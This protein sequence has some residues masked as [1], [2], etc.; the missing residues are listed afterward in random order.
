MSKVNWRDQLRVIDIYI[1]NQCQAGCPSCSRFD[2][3]LWPFLLDHTK[4]YEDYP[5]KVAELLGMD[6]MPKEKVIRLL[7]N[8]VPRGLDYC[9]KFCGEF[10]DPLMHPHIGD[11]VKFVCKRQNN[12][13]LLHT[14]GGLRNKQWWIDIAQIIERGDVVFSIDGTTAEVNN[15]YRKRVNF[16]RAMENMCAFADNCYEGIA[17]WDYL[18]FDWNWHQIKEANDIAKAHNIGID[19][20]IQDRSYGLISS[21]NR[22]KALDIIHAL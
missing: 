16:D 3:P 4:N 5:Y 20:K 1:T 10:G 11:L 12:R 8:N 21:E 2:M 15:Y 13:V 6:H 14:N 22:R 19:F 17:N 18:V 9:I 7:K